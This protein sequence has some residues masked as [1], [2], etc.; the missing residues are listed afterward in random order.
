MNGLFFATILLGTLIST[1]HLAQAANPPF[2]PKEGKLLIIG[3]QKDSIEGY[4]Q[5]IGIVPGGLMFYTS[6]Q[7]MDGLDRPANH[8]A[9]ILYAQYFIN[10]YPNT[11]I[12]LALYMVG[13]LDNTL[14]GK[15]DQNILKLA[16][17][18]KSVNRPIYFRIGYEFDLPDN[19]YDP[20]KYQQAY[21]YIVDHLRSQGVTNVAYVWHS[22]CLI[23]PNGDFMDWYPGDDY[24]DWFAVSI[25]NPM[26]IANAKIMATFAT[27]HFKPFMI[28][29]STPAGLVSTEAKKEWFRHYFDF[30][31]D[32]DVKVVCY[33][34]SDWNS[35]PMFQSMDWG[36]AQIQDDPE[37]KDRW[38]K[39]IGN[40]FL[41]SSP[42]LFD[43]LTEQGQY[44]PV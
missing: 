27:A 38:I 34:N 24:V 36:D 39:Q 1:C 15:Y 11:V 2:I 40:G 32:Q 25:F 44:A 37:I 17:W 19:G 16:N 35:Y 18:M 4:I 13:A 7:N 29:E 5:N 14:N 10:R 33:I 23:Q 8:G 9:G 28:A 21:R 22:A 42:D 26:Q 43:K 20:V 41:Q 31:R 30:I 6:I 12:Q 3:Q